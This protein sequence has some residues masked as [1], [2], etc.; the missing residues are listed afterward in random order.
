MKRRKHSAVLSAFGQGVVTEGGFDRKIGGIL[1]QRFDDRNDADYGP[2]GATN[3]EAGEAIAD[4][5]I[6]VDAVGRWLEQRETAD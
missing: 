5:V 3:S 6:F 4:A 1:R 2:G